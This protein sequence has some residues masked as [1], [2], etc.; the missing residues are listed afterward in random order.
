M[1]HKYQKP[2]ISIEYWSVTSDQL[3]KLYN[4]FN[5]RFPKSNIEITLTTTGQHSRICENFKEYLA[6]VAKIISN[7]EVVSK[8][9]IIER[10]G[11]RTHTFKQIWIEISF[12]KHSSA[13]IHVIGGDT[14]GSYKD[15]IEGAYA[16]LIKLKEIFELKNDKVVNILNKEY[17]KIIFD[18]NG[19][20][21]EKITKS[22]EPPEK[23]GEEQ[24]NT[25]TQP[26]WWQQLLFLVIVGVIVGVIVAIIVYFLGLN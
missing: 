24:K 2:T 18:P 1:K 15:W 5:Q 16:E 11:S 19:K 9:E 8:I 12:G 20:I 3:K 4:F 21:L 23:K 7:N 25:Q 22:L 13:T 6:E 17:N 26:K 10:E 14:D